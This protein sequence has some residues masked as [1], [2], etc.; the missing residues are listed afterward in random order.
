LIYVYFEDGP[1]R[2]IGGQ[3]AHQRLGAKDRGQYREAAGVIEE[4]KTMTPLTTPSPFLID[5]IVLFDL[6]ALVLAVATVWL[7]WYVVKKAFPDDTGDLQFFLTFICVIVP[8]VLII[9][10][11][12]A[13]IHY[14]S[15]APRAGWPPV[16]PLTGLLSPL[17]VGAVTFY[18]GQTVW[19][20]WDWRKSRKP[21]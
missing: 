20:W 19:L 15:I 2:R 18:V 6:V 16:L 10:F 1:G 7:L 17:I 13:V 8:F 12:L 5:E 14:D 3:A 4:R 9:C 11:G 21:Q